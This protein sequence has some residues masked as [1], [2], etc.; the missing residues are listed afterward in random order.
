MIRL[1]A[2]LVDL[3]IGLAVWLA[4]VVAA[5]AL[6]QHFMFGFDPLVP[7]R[8]LRL[9]TAWRA[10]RLA[11]TSDRQLI[12]LAS[13][14][15]SV[16]IALVLLVPLVRIGFALRAGTV[17]Q[18]NRLV[19]RLLK[20]LAA[21]SQPSKGREPGRGQFT[22]PTEPTGTNAPRG[23]EADTVASAS[24][25]GAGDDA[26]GRPEPAPESSAHRT[27]QV[28]RIA[29]EATAMLRA[30]AEQ[31]GGNLVEEDRNGDPA[32]DPTE[33]VPAEDLRH[34]Q[35]PPAPSALNR[36]S[37]PS[38]PAQPAYDSKG[39]QS[40]PAAWASDPVPLPPRSLLMPIILA[41][42]LLPPWLKVF[43]DIRVEA[44]DR[45]E[46]VPFVVAGDDRLTFVVPWPYTDHCK[47]QDD[48]GIW[49]IA[50]RGHSPSPV[51][52]ALRLALAARGGLPAALAAS[53]TIVPMVVVRTTDSIQDLD[54]AKADWRELRVV[55][56][57]LS[58]APQPTLGPAWAAGLGLP[59]LNDAL[60]DGAAVAPSEDLVRWLIEH[61]AGS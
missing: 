17:K 55:V 18:V 6:V 38:P 49:T 10:G 59:S 8:W 41:L 21:T 9:G 37:G 52:T 16:V 56:A 53:V 61:T 3:A 40:P 45:P 30:A 36:V 7:E 4:T 57:S 51:R 58:P 24:G 48:Q 60:A 43:T 27:D 19:S 2:A 39:G 25:V 46:L 15:I 34:G 26:Y 47:P 5:F 50:G 1:I 31:S 33:T 29:N 11:F 35:S 23:A 12:W 42:R 14:P 32:P 44:D 22:T 13:G 54:Q 28:E 20:R